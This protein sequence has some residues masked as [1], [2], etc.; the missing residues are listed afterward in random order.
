MER[1]A[2]AKKALVLRLPN[3][4][5]VLQRLTPLGLVDVIFTHTTAPSG[6]AMV[7]LDSARVVH[8]KRAVDATNS[9]T[10]PGE[11]PKA[12]GVVGCGMPW[13]FRLW[14]SHAYSLGSASSQSGTLF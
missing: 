11:G 2:F 5:V 9:T 12:S 14:R 10:E 13:K 8:P 7:R 4:A 6:A 3:L 1:R